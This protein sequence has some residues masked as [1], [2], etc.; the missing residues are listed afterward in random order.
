MSAWR[1]GEETRQVECGDEED[2]GGTAAEAAE[3][4]EGAADSAGK[5]APAAPP[6]PK[7]PV[8]HEATLIEEF[9]KLEKSD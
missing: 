9:D 3:G 8:I 5:A 6:A 2:E 4:S 7:E 1:G